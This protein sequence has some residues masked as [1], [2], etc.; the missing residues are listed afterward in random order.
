MLGKGEWAVRRGGPKIF[1]PK[2]IF[3]KIFLKKIFSPKIFLKKVGAK[4][5]CCPQGLGWYRAIARSQPSNGYLQGFLAY[6]DR[7]LSFSA[8]R[9]LSI[10]ISMASVARHLCPHH[11]CFLSE[12]I[13]NNFCWLSGEVQFATL[14]PALVPRRPGSVWQII[15]RLLTWPFA[16]VPPIEQARDN[17]L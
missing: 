5:L 1:L 8:T 15:D 2:S 9:F 17:W 11:Q 16:R 7:Y 13:A 14:I 3:T 10:L 6:R 12:Q 4:P